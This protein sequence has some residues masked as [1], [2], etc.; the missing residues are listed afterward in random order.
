MAYTTL[1]DPNATDVAELNQAS[2]KW[3]AVMAGDLLIRP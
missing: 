2:N 3:K 1:C